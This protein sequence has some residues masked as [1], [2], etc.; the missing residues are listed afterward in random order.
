MSSAG[1][2]GKMHVLIA[3]PLYPPEAGGPATYS[4][5]LEQG[6][7]GRGIEVSMLPFARVRH[8]PKLVRHVRYLLYLVIHGRN[9]DLLLAL[10]P[11]S[12]GLPVAVASFLLRKPYVVKVVGDYAWEQGR[13][14]HGIRMSLDEFITTA[15][16]PF[17]TQVLRAVESF[18]ARRAQH[19]IV[20]SE[21]LKKVVQTWGVNRDRVTVIYNAV[22]HATPSSKVPSFAPASG[23]KIVTVGRLVP[24]KGVPGLIDSLARVRNEVP[25]ATLVIVGDGPERLALETYARARLPESAVIFTGMRSHADTLA[26]MRDADIFVLNSSYEGLSH[27]LIEAMSL[28]RPIVATR[29]GGNTELITD[30]EDGL[31]ANVGDSNELGEKILELLKNP[32]KAGSLGERARKRSEDFSEERMIEDTTAFLKTCI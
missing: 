25:D 30:G 9:A 28:A 3:T 32:E 19:L 5:A 17:P 23:E 15:H 24:W 2:N 11:V 21:Y 27:V 16:I 8:L 6:L 31:L 1:Y 26:I 12:V 18:V 13:Q 22:P 4:R 29:A 7:P 20:P 10:D 14:R